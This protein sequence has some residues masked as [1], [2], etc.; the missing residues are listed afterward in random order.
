MV[1]TL[2]TG[3]HHGWEVTCLMTGF[4]NRYAEGCESGEIHQQ[5]VDQI[6]EA[7]VV[8]ASDDGTQCHTVFPTQRMVADKGV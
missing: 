8:V 4:I 5:V 1:L 6:A 2:K 3:L 7:G